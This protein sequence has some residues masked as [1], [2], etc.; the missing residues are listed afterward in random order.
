MK[1]IRTSVG[2]G[3]LPISNL[4]TGEVG[5][6]K[7]ALLLICG[8]GSVLKVRANEFAPLHTVGECMSTW[9]SLTQKKV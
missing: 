1:L 9:I 8:D 4:A 5:V 7:E 3:V 6:S 2:C